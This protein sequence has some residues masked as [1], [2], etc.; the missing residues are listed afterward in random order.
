MGHHRGLRVICLEMWTAA[1][2]ARGP[3]PPP[4]SEN[5]E[6]EK[7]QRPELSRDLDIQQG[8]AGGGKGFIGTGREVKGK[9]AHLILINTS[10]T[11]EELGAFCTVLFY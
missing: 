4:R 8:S 10:C 9:P 2:G 11:G 3:P 6:G 1:V 5:T 7:M